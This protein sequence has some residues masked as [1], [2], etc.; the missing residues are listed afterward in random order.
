[1][2]GYIYESTKLSDLSILLLIFKDKQ[3]Y[4][5]FVEDFHVLV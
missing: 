1:M 3:I 2:L 4:Y 5:I